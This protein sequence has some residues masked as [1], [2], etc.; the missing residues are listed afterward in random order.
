LTLGAKLA[1]SPVYVMGVFQVML[2]LIL[3][4]EFGVTDDATELLEWNFN[5]IFF[6]HFSGNT[7][8]TV[9]L[10]NVKVQSALRCKCFVA[11]VALEFHL[12]KR[13]K[14]FNLRL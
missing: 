8:V 11:S 10:R 5:F 4:R 6:F 1:V 13:K 7:G 9:I 2:P 12:G 14:N 3:T